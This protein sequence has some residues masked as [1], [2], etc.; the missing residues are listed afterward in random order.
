M[1]HIWLGISGWNYAQW[2]GRFYPSDLPRRRELAYASRQ[3]NSIEINATFYGL[4]RPDTYRTWYAETPRGFRFAVKGNRFITH[5]KRLHDVETALA[6]FFAS[7]VLRLNEK[8]GPI[9]WQFPPSLAFDRQRVERFL[10]LLPHHTEAAARLAARHDGHLPGRAALRSDRRRRLR[11][12]LEV[13]HESFCVPGFANLARRY[14]TALVF[15]DS[16]DWPYTEQLTAGYVYLRLHGSPQ[17]YVSAYSDGALER[18]A[19]RIRRWQAGEQPP[20]AARISNRK[21]P[22][23]KRRDVYVYFDNDKDAHAPDDARRLG[24]RLGLTDSL[25]GCPAF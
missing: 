8:L 21:P 7:G 24:D 11:H 16:G 22:P 1:A 25:S 10:A 12:A 23:R 4:L 14:G 2:R 19:E 20:D 18:W 5:T 9:I 15:A 17:T 6:N 3:F 13:R